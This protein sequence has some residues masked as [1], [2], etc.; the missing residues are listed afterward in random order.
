MTESRPF[1][2][3][4][5]GPAGMAA[6]IEAARSG[7]PCTLI[8]EA[9]SLGGQIYRRPIDPLTPA[10][11]SALG[12]D[13]ARG[14]RLRTEFTA[15][16]NRIEVLLNTFV[17]DVSDGHDVMWASERAS[18]IIRA[19]QLVIAAGAYDRPIPFPGWTLPGVMTAGGVQVLIKTMQVKPGRRALVAGTGPLIVGVAKR[20]HEIGVEVVAVLEAASV[21]WSRAVFPEEWAEWSLV[22]DTWRAWDILH[23]AGIPV[24]PGHTVFEARGS[25]QVQSAIY[26]PVTPQDWRPLRHQAQ[27]VDVDLIVCGFGFV[28]NT[29]LTVLAGCRHQ[30]CHELGGWMPVIDELVR[31]S[32]PGIFAAGDGAGVAGALVALEE[33]RVAGTTAA[34]QAGAITRDEAEK[35]RAGPLQRLT[36]LAELRRTLDQISWIRPGLLEL[37]SPD[38]LLCRCEEVRLSEVQAAFEQGARDLQAT[39]L[40]TRLGMGPCQGRN[41]APSTGMYLCKVMGRTAEEVGRINPRPPVKPVT[42]GSLA[43]MSNV[44]QAPAGDPLDAVNTGGAL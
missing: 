14:E 35:R 25:Q 15:A 30:Y 13:F 40:F 11:P 24:L 32:V 41:C 36:A 28:P 8:D 39:K 1:V 6:A 34:E 27:S 21:S 31:T 12:D 20:L 9:R 7:L 43:Q 3:I 29:E 33:G 19:E 23:Q 44:G 42:L 16:A 17:L 18:G 10:D 2:V 4:G 26:G 22:Y 5:G 37:A 38:T